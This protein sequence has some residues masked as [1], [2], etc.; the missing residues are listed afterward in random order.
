MEHQSRHAPSRYNDRAAADLLKHYIEAKQWSG[1]EDDV[2]V[3]ISMR[4]FVQ[5]VDIFRASPADA[6][7]CIGCAFRGNA[8]MQFDLL[9]GRRVGRGKLKTI[10]NVFITVADSVS[11]PDDTERALCQWSTMTLATSRKPNDATRQSF[12]RLCNDSI[13]LQHKLPRR[14]AGDPHLRDDILRACH[15]EPFLHFSQDMSTKNSYTNLRS[16]IL[17]AIKNFQA[18]VVSNHPAELFAIAQQ[19][20]FTADTGGAPGALDGNRLG[21]D[22]KQWKCFGCGSTMHL[23]GQ[24]KSPSREDIRKDLMLRITM[25]PSCSD[26]GI[27]RISILS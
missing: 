25:W 6:L 8:K 15:N 26:R 7:K 12:D 20:R 16:A 10:R 9:I 11:V 22:G 17:T 5:A 24:C 13:R 4:Q 19:R 23:F 14:Y 3:K 2:G 27:A 1:P 21:K 18:R